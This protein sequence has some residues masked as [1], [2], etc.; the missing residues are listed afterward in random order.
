MPPREGKASV[1]GK[2]TVTIHKR[3]GGKGNK[4]R[5]KNSDI[6][7]IQKAAGGRKT[8]TEIPTEGTKCC[9]E[10]GKA[11]LKNRSVFGK[12]P[13]GVL[14]NRSVVWKPRVGVFKTPDANQKRKHRVGGSENDT[15]KSVRRLRRRIEEAGVK[16]RTWEEVVCGRKDTR[17]S[18]LTRY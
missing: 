17:A 3:Y 7:R 14:D 11:R 4:R 15:K 6:V 9:T 12:T 5:L 1:T 2:W 8:P 16:H 10:V 18:C 13:V